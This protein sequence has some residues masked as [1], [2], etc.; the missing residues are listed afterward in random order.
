MSCNQ[1]FWRTDLI[2]VNGFDERM[3]GWGREDTE[4]A[5]R[6][7]NAGLRRLQLRHTAL[8]VHLHHPPRGHGDG[9]NPNDAYLAATEAQGRT[10]CEAGLDGHRAEFAAPPPDLRRLAAAAYAGEPACA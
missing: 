10:R 4:L 1:G 3:T 6:C 9:P 2:A 8:A 5:V 7:Y